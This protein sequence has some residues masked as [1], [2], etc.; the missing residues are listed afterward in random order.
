M[1]TAHGLPSSSVP[2]RLGVLRGF[3]GDALAVKIDLPFLKL[4]ASFCA[5]LGAGAVC[6]SARF[7]ALWISGD[8]GSAGFAP[9]SLPAS[10]PRSRTR[11]CLS[12]IQKQGTSVFVPASRIFFSC[13]A[14]SAPL[15]RLNCARVIGLIFGTGRFHVK[16]ACR[17]K[18]LNALAHRHH[19]SAA[20]PVL[21]PTAPCEQAPSG[22]P[23]FRQEIR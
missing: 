19:F 4:P 20:E 8:A 3:D 7:T 2:L 16:I 15:A 21:L 22:F 1:V 5:A 17:V 11:S 10:V 12:Q 6:A 9:R 23:P 14:C 13:A 18:R